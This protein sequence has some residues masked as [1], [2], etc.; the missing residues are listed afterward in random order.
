MEQTLIPA[1]RHELGPARHAALPA[2]LAAQ[3]KAGSG[4]RQPEN[5]PRASGRV[6]PR[7]WLARLHVHL[8]VASVPVLAI[9][10]HVFWLV[11]LRTVALFVLLPLVAVLAL[12]VAAR[13]HCSDRVVLAGFLW[14]L[15]ACAGYDALRLPTVYV[16]HWWSDFFPAVGGWAIGGHSSVLVGYLWRYAGDGGGIAVAFFAIAATLGAGSWPWRRIMAL[17]LAYA[18]CPVWLGLVLTNVLAPGGRQLFPLSFT[19]VTL[20]LAGHLIYGAVLGL[21]YWK[22][23]HLEGFWPLR[24]ADL[25]QPSVL[26]PMSW[27]RAGS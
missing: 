2:P 12:F 15:L 11:S 7:G 9:S 25:P 26:R 27:A 5:P 24:L 20:C 16:A 10:A 23:R 14:G 3:G 17:G 1:R 21:G 13:P 8:A 4:S 6:A 22:S 19:T 18:V